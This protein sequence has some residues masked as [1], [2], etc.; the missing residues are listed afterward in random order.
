MQTYTNPIA[1][2]GDFADPFVLRFNGRYYL[3]CTNADL[4]CWSSTD[5]LHWTLEGPTIAPGTFGDLMPFAPEVTYDNGVFHLYTSPSGTGHR[6]L[7]S[8]CPTGP[9][10]P[11]TGNI[12]HAIDGHVFVDDD[13]RRY[14]YWAGDEGIW[15]C[16]MASPTELGEPVLTGAFMHGW[17][18]GPFVIKR[19]G[20]YHMT[21]TGNHYLSPGYRI[22]AAVSDHPLHGYRDSPLNPVLLSTSPGH[23][24]LGHSSSVLGPDLVSTYLV[25]HNLNPDLSRDLNIDRQLWTGDLLQ[26]LGPSRLAPTP[27]APDHSTRWGADES[28]RWEVRT[29]SLAEHSDRASLSGP[30]RVLWRDVRL[31][32]RFTSEHTVA[33]TAGRYGLLAGDPAREGWRID[34]EPETN[35]LRVVALGAGATGVLA[36]ATLPTDHRHDALHCYRLVADDGRIELFVDSRRQLEFRPEHIAGLTLG[37]HCDDGTLTIGHTALTREVERCAS[38]AAPRPVPGRFLAAPPAPSSGVSVQRLFV[39]V[40]GWHDL[41]LAGEFPAGAALTVAVGEQSTEPELAQETTAITL[42]LWLDQGEHVLA[43]S[44]EGRAVTLRTVDIRPTPDPPGEFDRW[45]SSGTGKLLVPRPTVGDWDLT[46]TVRIGFDCPDGHADLLFCASEPAEGGEG[47]D[48]TLGIDFLLGY[49]LQFHRRR[50]VLARHAYDER[51]VAQRDVVIDYALPHTI[52][53]SRR[54]G[55]ITARIDDLEA[56]GFADPWPHA[57]GRLGLRTRDARIAVE[58][59]G[60]SAAGQTRALR[61]LSN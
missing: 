39:P 34:V 16:E 35:R 54:G 40:A 11:V 44:V 21:L 26:I 57:A 31:P 17:T 19:D 47:D 53:I 24:G 50:V 8:D 13:G 42:P 49:S 55:R 2:D 37:Y 45:E 32:D 28:G 6:I 38:A 4:R 41:C 27:A 29:G 10:V 18:E 3:Y 30:G 52:A 61:T 22:N 25:Y 20:L 56:L 48:T 58:Q 33:A 43:I 15:G 9:F 51:P 5:L 60:L 46:A 1:S 12:G 14:F 36:T 59:F 23:L 7:R